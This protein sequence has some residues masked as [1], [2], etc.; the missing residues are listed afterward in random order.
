MSDEDIAEPIDENEDGSEQP[1]VE[2]PRSQKQRIAYDAE[3][4]RLFWQQ[5][6][7]HPVGRREMWAI[8]QSAHTFEERFACGPNGFPQPEAT[9]FEAGVQSFG[10]RLQRTWMAKQ[11]EGYLAMLF[12]NDP[13]F[14]KPSPPKK[15]RGQP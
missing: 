7:A 11:P 1:A 12:E 9:W 6:F 10:Q 4:A 14:P 2:T 13:Q 8:L 5:V 3:Q 15:K